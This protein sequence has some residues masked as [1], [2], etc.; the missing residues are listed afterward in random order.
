MSLSIKTAAHT[1]ETGRISSELAQVKE[2]HA[3]YVADL[4]RGDQRLLSLGKERKYINVSPKLG[5]L[6]AEVS[7]AMRAQLDRSLEE[8]RSLV[9]EF[10][11]AITERDGQLRLLG[12]QILA[13]RKL[14]S[15]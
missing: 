11:S 3:V 9:K 13:D 4:K 12:D 8:G 5:P 10:G 1:Q 7:Q 6:S 2:H 15:N 14:I